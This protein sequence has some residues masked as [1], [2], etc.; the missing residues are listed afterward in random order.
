MWAI[1]EVFLLAENTHQNKHIL[2]RH[3][4]TIQASLSGIGQQ[5]Q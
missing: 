1:S 5:L 2:R 3:L 4:E